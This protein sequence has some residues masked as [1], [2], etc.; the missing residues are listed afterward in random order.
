LEPHE[1]PSSYMKNL[2][3]LYSSVMFQSHDGGKKWSVYK[4]KGTG[5]IDKIIASKDK[6]L[7]KDVSD[8]VGNNITTTEDLELVKGMHIS[9]IPSLGTSPLRIIKKKKTSVT[10]KDFEIFKNKVLGR[11]SFGKVMLCKKKHSQK[12]F[13]IKIV[14]K[15][16]ND[17]K[18]RMWIR[19][20][21]DLMAFSNHESIANLHY[22][23]QDYKKI[24]FVMDFLQGG[25][26][27]TLLN[28]EKKISIDATRI[29]IG[30]ICL[31]VHFVHCKGYCHRDIKPANILFD[32]YG[33]AKLSD[34]GFAKRLI[35]NSKLN[36]IEINPKQTLKDK[37]LKTN[38]K[39]IIKSEYV[40]KERIYAKSKVGTINYGS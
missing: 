35:K 39:N 22:C 14:K 29:Y 26:L 40:K 17:G 20:E 8:K 19:A 13:A 4:K 25:D 16:N 10:L 24:Y 5:K 38:N 32:K 33:H 34:F 30:Q 7:K 21:R 36:D 2:S 1:D 11:G 31:G 15:K 28:R 37:K 27:L 23:F 3:V 18:E 9:T 12:I 6:Y